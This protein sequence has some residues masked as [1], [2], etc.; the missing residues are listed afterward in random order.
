MMVHAPAPPQVFARP[1]HVPASQ[2]LRSYSASGLMLPMSL[3]LA[4]LTCSR[5]THLALPVNEEPAPLGLAKQ[6][7]QF[8]DLRWLELRSSGVTSAFLD[9]LF[10]L[11]CL[12][13]LVMFAS[14][15]QG[16][17]HAS[18]IRAQGGMAEDYHP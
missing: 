10:N 9:Q 2:R 3:C 1:R 4:V 8:G 15:A 5:L 7:A 16:Q 17:K 12:T 6:I 11:K 18:A 13:K 14:Q